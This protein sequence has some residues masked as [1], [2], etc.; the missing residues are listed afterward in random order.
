MKIDV[1]IPTY[2]SAH[3]IT[4]AIS[5]VQT[6]TYAPE[7]II[8]VDDGSTDDTESIISDLRHASTVPLM[9]IKKENG[10]PNSARNVGLAHATAELVAFLDAD[11]RWGP[12]K[13][14]QQVALFEQDIDGTLGLVYGNYKV[15]DTAGADRP[16]VPT[17]KLDPLVRGYAFAALLPGNLILGS[18]SNVLIRRSVFETVGMFDET[19]RIG[20]DWDMWLRIAEKYI[21]E[22]VNTVLVAIRRHENNQTKNIAKLIVGDSAFIEKWVP[23]IIG[24]YSIPRIWGDRIVFNIIRGLPSLAN[25]RIANRTLSKQT[26]KVVFEYTRGSLA[27]ACSMFIIRTLTNRELRKRMITSLKRYVTR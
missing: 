17:V 11:D 19:L 13:L 9:Y 7:Q 22:Y 24:A 4:E 8:I 21:I 2:N 5:S 18:A 20:E 27:L 25:F 1:I 10:G 15:I 16:D 6:Q 23:R 3:F 26:K 14:A 12:T